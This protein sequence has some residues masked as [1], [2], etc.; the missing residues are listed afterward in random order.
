MPVT[1]CQSGQGEQREGKREE[2][3][4]RERGERETQSRATYNDMPISHNMMAN[5]AT[6]VKILV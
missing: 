5:A 1:L 6:K 4:E 2:E 3:R